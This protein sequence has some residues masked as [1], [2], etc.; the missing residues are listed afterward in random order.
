MPVK[1]FLILSEMSL[2]KTL[3]GESV[4]FP[5]L[6]LPSFPHSLSKLAMTNTTPKS[7][8]SS[9][10]RIIAEQDPTC[11]TKP[12][13]QS[14]CPNQQKGGKG[15]PKQWDGKLPPKVV[16]SVPACLS[17]AMSLQQQGTVLKAPRGNSPTWPT[18]FLLTHAVRTTCKWKELKWQYSVIAVSGKC[19]C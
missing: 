11:C 19:T 18:L 12:C 17:L 6:F 9:Q 4:L 13:A 15:S 16:H 3:N 10:K 1:F 14:H 8:P 2:K 5:L 7:A